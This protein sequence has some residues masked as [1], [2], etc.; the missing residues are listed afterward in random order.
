MPEKYT[1]FPDFDSEAVGQALGAE[2]QW[3][4]DVAHGEGEVLTIGDGRAE[5]QVYPSAGVARVTTADAR[6][7]IY[8][9]PGYSVN[10][11]VGR[12]VFE[13]GADDERTRLLVQRN[14][15]VSFHPVLRATGAPQTA[16]TTV[17][18]PVDQPTLQTTSQGVLEQPA[19]PDTSAQESEERPTLTL[20]GRLGQDPWFTRDN[21][22][23][24]AG[25][26]LA[27]NHDHG[28]TTTWHTVKARGEAADQVDAGQKA[29]YIRRGKQVSVTG[30]YGEKT[31]KGKPPFEATAVTRAQAKPKPSDRQ[32]D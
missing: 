6:V 31:G 25:F 32:H 20:T 18:A 2:A 23:L 16:D 10:P 14:G 8:R 28:T 26:P 24:V 21:D 22:M 3:L 29:G 17:R 11:D 9:V 13:Q 5:L 27:V 4:R 19:S 30:S 15:K 12:V 7:E 1:P